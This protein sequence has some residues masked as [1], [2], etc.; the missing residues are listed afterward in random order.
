VEIFNSA[1]FWFLEGILFCFVITGFKAW[2]EDRS[3]PM[4]LWKWILFVA[5]LAFGGFTIAFVGTSIGE[6]EANAALRGAVLFGI[7]AVVSGF[8]L[9]RLIKIG[10]RRSA[11]ATTNIE[12]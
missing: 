4:P 1:L 11:K 12:G 9:W 3:I 2:M 8:G 10:S 6:G 5:W 7:I